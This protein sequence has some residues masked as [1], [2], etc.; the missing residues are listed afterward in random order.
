MSKADSV[1]KGYFDDPE[2]T[3]EVLKTDGIILGIWVILIKMV[4]CGMP[5]GSRDLQRSVVKWFHLSRSK[6]H[7]KSFSR[8]GLN[9]VW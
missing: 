7:S 2:Q 5:G 4:I 6:I 9:V 8:K 1:M 3:A